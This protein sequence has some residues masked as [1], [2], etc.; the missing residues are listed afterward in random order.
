[1]LL[2]AACSPQ[3]FPKT[4]STFVDNFRVLAGDWDVEQVKSLPRPEGEFEAALFDEYIRLGAAERAEADWN[5][6]TFFLNRARRLSRQRVPDPTPI[7][8]RNMPADSLDEFTD[9]RRRLMI[10]LSSTRRFRQPVESARAQASFDCW[11][12]EREENFQTDDIN[13]CRSVFLAEIEKLEATKP[14]TLVVLLPD[15]DGEV[16]E[17]VFTTGAGTQVL[18]GERSATTAN[19]STETPAAPFEL[20]QASVDKTFGPAI[21]AQPVP[22]DRFIIFFEIRSSDLTDTSAAQIPQII[23]SI[24]RHPAAEVDIVGHAD[25]SGSDAYNDALSLRRATEIRQRIIGAVANEDAV[26]ITAKGESNPVVDTPDGV[27]E[28]QNRRVEVTVR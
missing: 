27:A 20:E 3:E 25:R 22:P 14:R 5:D 16:G 21:G 13:S 23:D 2:L 24:S 15:L 9:A 1:M 26:T 11:M 10:A 12:Q 4:G 7:D 6:T 19:R 17:V 18:T 8:L 28:P